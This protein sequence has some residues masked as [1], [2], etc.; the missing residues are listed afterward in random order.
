MCV[1]RAVFT[2]TLAEGKYKEMFANPS[3][4]DQKASVKQLHEA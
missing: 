4:V 1:S 2:R 3:E